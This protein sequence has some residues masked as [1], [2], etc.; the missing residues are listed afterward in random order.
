MDQTSAFDLYALG[1]VVKASGCYCLTNASGDVLYIG[2]AVNLRRR[3]MQHFDSDKRGALTEY[4]RISVVWWRL[5]VAIRLD[6]LERGWIN[7]AML[8]DG[9]LPPLNR[10]TG[11]I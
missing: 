2:Q 4:G 9:Q 11:H 8:S 3:L 7:A 1:L 6:A 5:E 10:V